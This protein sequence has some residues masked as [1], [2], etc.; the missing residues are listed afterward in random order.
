MH[1]TTKQKGKVIFYTRES[2]SLYEHGEC[3]VCGNKFLVK[4]GCNYCKQLK[5]QFLEK[6]KK[7]IPTCKAGPTKLKRELFDNE[8][9]S[10]KYSEWLLRERS[11]DCQFYDKCLLYACEKGWRSFSCIWC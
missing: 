9:K 6:G 8:L 5:Q 2:K 4:V 1:T 10:K 11:F 3:F 7:I